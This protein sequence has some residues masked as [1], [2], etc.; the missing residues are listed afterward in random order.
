MLQHIAV[1]CRAPRRR[2][3]SLLCWT[4][5]SLLLQRVAVYCS[6]MQRVAVC[7]SVL[8]GDKAKAQLA[9]VL[10]G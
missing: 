4:G 2:R 5:E 9:A 7:C 10:R 6:V 3:S 8:Q 1:R